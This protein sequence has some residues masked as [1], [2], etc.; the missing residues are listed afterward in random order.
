MVVVGFCSA[1]G[2]LAQA[3]P[4]VAQSQ[5]L[6]P[7]RNLIAPYTPP[8][9]TRDQP[10]TWLVAPEEPAQVSAANPTN[11]IAS[12][13]AASP[14]ATVGDRIDGPAINTLAA[15]RSAITVSVL[16]GPR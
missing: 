7:P 2:A 14:A 4:E 15:G 3:T 5:A 8:V 6:A 10:L 12:T 9:Q 11:D 16:R 13:H 1:T